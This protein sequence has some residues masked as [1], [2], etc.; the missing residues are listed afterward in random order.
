MGEI[1]AGEARHLYALNPV[2]LVPLGSHEDQGPH[3]P[4][5]DYLLADGISLRAATRA[6]ELG[7]HTVVAPTLPY[8]GADWFGPMPGGI[9]ISPETLKSLLL[10]VFGSL[11]RHDLTRIIV[12]NGHGGNIGPISEVTREIY[13][14]RR[15]LIPSVNIWQAA[16]GFL[17]KVLGF[18]TAKK[19]SGH[20]ADPVTSVAMYLMP[21]C[22]RP[23]LTPPARPLRTDPTLGLRFNT[24]GSADFEGV[25]IGMPNEYDEV[26]Q[27]GMGIGDPQYCSAE[28]GEELTTM[29]VET[30]AK[31]SVQLANRTGFCDSEKDGRKRPTGFATEPL[32]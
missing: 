26:F 18:E 25:A 23:D 10:D 6:T 2:V 16:Y 32:M 14:D 24:M 30:I 31:L 9:A 13:R 12:I 21:D 15:I 27:E 1:T 17:P 7:A 11:L 4:M 3:A 19:A 5:G 28:T 8:G 29:L 20:G 22:M